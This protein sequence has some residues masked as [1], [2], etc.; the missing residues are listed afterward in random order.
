MNIEEGKSYYFYDN[1]ATDDVCKAHVLSVLPHP[2]REDDRLIVYRWYGKHRQRWWYGV[3]TISQQELWAEYCQKVVK[4]NKDQRKECKKCGQCG[5]FMRY[6]QTCSDKETTG[7]CANLAMNKECNENKVDPF[8]P[9]AMDEGYGILKVD[10][11]ETACGL[12]RIGRTARVRRI[13]KRY[14]KFYEQL[15]RTKV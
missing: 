12:F 1:R 9:W 2:E 15:R 3:T 6:R 8:E 7:D 5:Y 14:P 4:Y 10:E 13:I 11:D